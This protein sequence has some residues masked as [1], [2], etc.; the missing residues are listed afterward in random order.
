MLTWPE[1]VKFAI[2]LLPA[3]LGGQDYVQ[4]Q[5]SLSVKEWMRKQVWQLSRLS[6][7]SKPLVD[8]SLECFTSQDHKKAS[9]TFFSPQ[10]RAYLIE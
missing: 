7:V 5:D 6:A 2:G 4:A 1:K 9:I 8:L 10:C 3:I